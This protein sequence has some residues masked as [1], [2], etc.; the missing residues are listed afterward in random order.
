MAVVTSLA[1]RTAEA[2]EQLERG[3]VRLLL[4]FGRAHP[5]P[6]CLP[7]PEIRVPADRS[8]FD[9]AAAEIF[10][11]LFTEHGHRAQAWITAREDCTHLPDAVVNLVHAAVLAWY[12]LLLSAARHLDDG[13]KESPFDPGWCGERLDEA[14]AEVDARLPKAL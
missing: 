11:N 6:G 3:R 8:G 4:L 9:E 1:I 2:Y 10:R 14:I 12:R 13:N 5:L 7:V